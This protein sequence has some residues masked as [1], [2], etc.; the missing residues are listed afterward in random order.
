MNEI[1]RAARGEVLPRARDMAAEMA[2]MVREV[3]RQM[4]A[5]PEAAT[6]TGAQEGSSV[7]V[8]VTVAPRDVG[9][10]IGKGGV[11]ARSLRTILDAAGTKNGVRVQLNINEA[12]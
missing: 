1:V 11:T 12:A 3:V 5:D 7:V 8:T 4:V 9:R 6:V 2:W 10:V